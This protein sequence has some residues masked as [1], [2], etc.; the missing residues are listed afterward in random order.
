MKDK[1]GNTEVW[2]HASHLNSQPWWLAK[3]FLKVGEGDWQY[4]LKIAQLCVILLSYRIIVAEISVVRLILIIYF[5]ESKM[6]HSKH[7]YSGFMLIYR[8]CH[9][10]NLFNSFSTYS[11][12]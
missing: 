11:K 5:T 12:K 9:N 8:I 6:H 3:I 4:N 2:S 1:T 10:F 7:I